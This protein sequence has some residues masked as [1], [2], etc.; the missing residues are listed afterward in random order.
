MSLD[1]RAEKR[2]R[3]STVANSLDTFI[4]FVENA[5][6]QLHSGGKVGMI[7]PSGWVRA[8]RYLAG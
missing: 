1:A 4:L 8:R 7:I 3:F 5:A 6:S 2:A